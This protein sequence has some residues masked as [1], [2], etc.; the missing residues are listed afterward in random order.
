MSKSTM[1]HIKAMVRLQSIISC[2]SPDCG[3]ADDM[4]DIMTRTWKRMSKQ[5]RLDV[6]YISSMLHDLKACH[7]AP[8]LLEE[9][10]SK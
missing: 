5:D 3:L 10:D 9:R 8:A 2:G 1:D 4:R 7:R 6:M